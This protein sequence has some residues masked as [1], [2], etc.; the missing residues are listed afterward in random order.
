[1]KQQVSAIENAISFAVKKKFKVLK[2]SIMSVKLPE[3]TIFQVRLLCLFS[4]SWKVFS[5]KTLVK[6]NHLVPEFFNKN[7]LD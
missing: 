6:D 4:I 7:A 1:M 5:S 2:V 3:G